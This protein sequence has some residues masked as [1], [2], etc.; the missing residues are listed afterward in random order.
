MNV[1]PHLRRG[2][3]CIVGDTRIAAR[4]T[5]R[6]P[7]LSL[8]SEWNTLVSNRVSRRAGCVLT[9]SRV[10]TAASG[11]RRAR[12]VRL[13]FQRDAGVDIGKKKSLKLGRTAKRG[14]RQRARS[15]IYALTWHRLQS[16]TL[17]AE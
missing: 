8:S 5:R 4:S 7:L 11:Q 14:Q 10:D 1:G 15:D 13:S 3:P 9:Q 2:Y 6:A 12:G 17:T 16:C